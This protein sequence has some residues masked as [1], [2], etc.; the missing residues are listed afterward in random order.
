MEYG[1]VM[2][3]DAIDTEIWNFDG[4]TSAGELLRP[5]WRRKTKLKLQGEAR[6]GIIKLKLTVKNAQNLWRKNFLR[7]CDSTNVD[8]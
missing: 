8:Y 4:N 2:S 7:H 3:A 5:A 6:N 1:A